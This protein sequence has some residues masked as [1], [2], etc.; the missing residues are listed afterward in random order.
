MNLLLQQKITYCCCKSKYY[1]F[2]WSACCKS[3]W[4]T[5]AL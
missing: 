1:K 3:N 2:L 4:K 5:I